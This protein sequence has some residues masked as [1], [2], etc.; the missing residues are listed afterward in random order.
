MQ[1][2]TTSKTIIPNTLII[3]TA[4]AF[5]SHIRIVSNLLVFDVLVIWQIAYYFL[6]GTNKISNLT[7]HFLLILNAF[8]L[9]SLFFLPLA[10]D[11]YGSSAFFFQYFFTFNAIP[12]YLDWLIREKKINFF[13]SSLLFVLVLNSILFIA[14]SLIKIFI[15]PS[16]SFLY[17]GQSGL[18]RFSWGHGIVSNDLIHYYILSLFIVWFL[19]RDRHQIKSYTFFS[20]AFLFTLSRTFILISAI[21]LIVKLNFEKLLLA[22]I[23]IILFV[24]VISKTNLSETIPNLNRLIYFQSLD[25]SSDPRIHNE[26][27]SKL[28]EP[29]FKNIEHFLW[30]PLFGNPNNIRFETTISVASVHNV[31]LSLLVNFGVLSTVFLLIIFLIYCYKFFFYLKNYWKI[32][33]SLNAFLLFIML[34]VIVISFNALMTSRPMWMS[35]F[36]YLYLYHYSVKSLI[37]QN[38]I[39]IP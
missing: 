12:I 29:I 32:I 2:I 27:R 37:K 31:Y 5:V 22:T 16:F 13:L 4:I 20:F 15:Y 34:D 36:L 17:F 25:Y 26:G 14:F 10:R 18:F 7:L 35:L 1:K 38:S 33:F 8:L 3:L 24:F 23:I 9:M 28:Q 30:F 6:T 21:F 19:Y 39:R 11:I